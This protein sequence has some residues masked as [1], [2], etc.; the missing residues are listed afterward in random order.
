MT[1]KYLLLPTVLLSLF[2]LLFINN[3]VDLRKNKNKLVRVNFIEAYSLL[4]S[5]TK[6]L[7]ISTKIGKTQSFFTNHY[8]TFAFSHGIGGGGGGHGG[9]HAGNRSDHDPFQV[10]FLPNKNKTVL[11]N[12]I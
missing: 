12:L 5:Y 6:V 11:S 1:K 10:F 4:T 9:S 8:L 3:R 7:P 2:T